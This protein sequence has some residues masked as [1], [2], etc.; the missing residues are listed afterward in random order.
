MVTSFIIV[1]EES[2]PSFGVKS[3]LMTVVSCVVVVSEIPC[4]NVGF[5][6]FISDNVPGPVNTLQVMVS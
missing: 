4:V 1:S 5:K 2:Q 6:L 3:A